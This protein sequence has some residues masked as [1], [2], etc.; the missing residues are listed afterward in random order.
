MDEIW[1]DIVGF[2]GLYQVSNLGRVKSVERVVNR[3][4]H[5]MRV[6][7]RILKPNLA[8]NGYLIVNLNRNGF[9]TK[10]I[11][12]LIAE[13]FIDNPDPAQCTCVEHLNA[14][15]TDNRIENLRWCS[16]VMNNNNQITRERMSEGRKGIKPSPFAVLRLVE[17][18][19]KKVCQLSLS[20]ELIKVW[21]SPSVASAMLGICTQTIYRCCNHPER[22]KTAGGYKWKYYEEGR[23]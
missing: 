15:K 4:G 1:K 23:H 13:N 17:L 21:Q 14:C 20:G 11:H 19:S 22:G 6:R 10:Y 7:E 16:Y 3:K 18:N 5:G 8:N 2:E 12:R 9:V